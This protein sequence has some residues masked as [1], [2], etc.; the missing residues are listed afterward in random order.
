[1]SRYCD[2]DITAVLEAAATW[3]DRFLLADGSILSEQALWVL[4]G[5]AE[6]QRFFIEQP[7]ATKR[8]F[9]E[10]LRDQ[11]APSAPQTKQLAAEMC[12]LL[13]L[14]PLA[15]AMGGERKRELVTTV[16]GMVWGSA[17]AGAGDAQGPLGG[18][19]GNPGTAYNTRLTWQASSASD[20]DLTFLPRMHTDISV[21]NAH[22]T[23]IIDA[24]YYQETLQH[25][26]DS[27]S[28]HSA[29]LYQLFAYVK[30]LEYRGARTRLQ[31]GFCCTRPS[32]TPCG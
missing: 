11:L 20:P 8:S 4:R 3:R 25:Y 19:V 27:A 18:W 12:W 9:V 32:S 6:L 1:M 23:I 28:I 26:Y 14:F 7:D 13:M 10:K 21:R 16:W 24:K 30:N 31:K 22:Q 2:H 17:P 29:H 15:R 5:L